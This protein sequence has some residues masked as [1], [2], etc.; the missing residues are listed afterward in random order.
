MVTKT[1]HNIG[2]TQT[3]PTTKSN[4]KGSVGS[5]TTWQNLIQQPMLV[6]HC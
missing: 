5:V 6:P 2:V 4:C 1:H 3:L